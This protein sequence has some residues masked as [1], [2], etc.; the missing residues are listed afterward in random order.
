MSPEII[1]D[2]EWALTIVRESLESL[3]RQYRDEGKGAIFDTLKPYLTISADREGYVDL[4][5]ELGVSHSGAKVAVHRIRKRYRK[6][7]RRCIT[8]TVHTP[9]EIDE[10]IN[11]L[12]D[13]LAHGGSADN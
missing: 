13:V 5:T 6:E 4:A 9:D 11:Y 3:E 8:E 7:I 2:R 10:E 12:M 1:F